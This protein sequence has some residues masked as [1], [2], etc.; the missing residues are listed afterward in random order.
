MTPALTLAQISDTHLLADITADLRG[1]NPWQ[2]LQAVLQQL[3][4]HPIDGLLL[5]GDLADQGSEAAYGHLYRALQTWDLPVYWLPGNHDELV[6]LQAV[7]QAHRFYGLQAIDLGCWRLLLLN[8]VWPQAKFGEGYLAT[9][10]LHWLKNELHQHSAKP[11]LIALHHHP[12]PTGID[13]VDQM[14]LKNS[15]ELLAVLDTFPQVQL[16]LFGHIHQALQQQ[17][18]S[19]SGSSLAFYGCP[20]TCLQVAPPIVCPNHHLPGFR[21]INL[22]PDGSH[23]TQVKRVQPNVVL[24]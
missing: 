11:T 18:I 14:L 23:N 7:F 8:S 1:C 6:T 22:Y 19:Q 16:V 3:A 24:P 21:L 10:Q 9:D 15:A 13:W 17:R 5:T 4:R 12:I 2:S 20:S